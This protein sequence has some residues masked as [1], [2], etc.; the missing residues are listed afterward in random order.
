MSELSEQQIEE[1][2]DI[3]DTFTTKSANANL[4]I[5][6][7]MKSCI[8]NK[9]KDDAYRIITGLNKRIEEDKHH[10]E[11]QEKIEKLQREIQ[12]FMMQFV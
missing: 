12:I 10:V 3:L 5:L 11:R 9:S 1:Q 4:Q 7:I 6:T 8:K 2:I